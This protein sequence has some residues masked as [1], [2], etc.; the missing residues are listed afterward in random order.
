MCRPE[1]PCEERRGA[2]ARDAPAAEGAPR[3]GAAGGRP[4][5]E[6]RARGAPGERERALAVPAHAARAHL[7]VPL[8]LPNSNP[9]DSTSEVLCD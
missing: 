8:P 7:C 4:V 1:I 2:D 3:D 9:L 5:L 6:A